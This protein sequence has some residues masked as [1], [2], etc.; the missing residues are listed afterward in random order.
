MNTDIETVQ[1]NNNLPAKL[2]YINFHA[3]EVVGRVQIT[4]FQTK[5]SQILMFQ[6]S[7]HSYQQ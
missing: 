1:F 6:H 3:L 2:S 5:R 4:Q 7:F